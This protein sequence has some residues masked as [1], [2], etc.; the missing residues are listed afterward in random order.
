MANFI[1]VTVYRLELGSDLTNRVVVTAY[2]ESISTTSIDKVVSVNSLM[3]ED[4]YGLGWLYA[5]IVKKQ[6]GTDQE[7]YVMNSVQ[8]IQNKLNS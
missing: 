6:P 2:P 5:K 3:G 7:F 1:N 8:D 4:I